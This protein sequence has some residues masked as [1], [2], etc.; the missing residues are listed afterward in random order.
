MRTTGQSTQTIDLGR[1]PEVRARAPGRVVIAMSLILGAG[2]D[3]RAVPAIARVV[4]DAADIKDVDVVVAVTVVVEEEEVAEAA[5][6]RKEAKTRQVHQPS[7]RTS[8]RHRAHQQQ[9]L[10][11]QRSHETPS[12]GDTVR[13]HSTKAIG[14]E[15][16]RTT[17][18]EHISQ[19]RLFKSVLRSMLA[20]SEG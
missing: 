9:E 12:L 8:R 5:E 16:A 11:E 10:L 7:R 6:V 14:A 19:S 20:R 3:I 17:L 13:P 4:A 18:L 15:S 2:L 1:V